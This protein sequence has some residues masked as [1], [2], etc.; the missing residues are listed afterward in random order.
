MSIM[1][2]LIWAILC[3]LKGSSLAPGAYSKNFG[4]QKL[5][6]SYAIAEPPYHI[7]YSITYLP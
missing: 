6:A 7:K 5:Y 3:G 4:R 2:I 1:F